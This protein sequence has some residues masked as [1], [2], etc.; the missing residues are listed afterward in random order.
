MI[1]VL[2]YLV[3]AWTEPTQSPP[4]GNVSAPL[5]VGNTGQSKSGGLIVNT[6]GAAVGFV[7]DKG[8]VGIGTTTPSGKLEVSGTGNVLLNTSGNVGIGTAYPSQK[9]EVSG[10]GLFT[11]D[12]CNGSGLCL[13]SVFQTNVIAGANANCPSGQIIIMKAWNGQ[14]YTADN[15]SITQWNKVSC[16]R[17]F[18]IDGTSLLVNNNHTGK[19]CTD[20]NG[21]VVNDGSG[22]N[23][24]RFK[25]GCGG[26][27]QQFNNWSTTIAGTCPTEKTHPFRK[28]SVCGASLP[29]HDWSNTP[30]EIYS[31]YG[32]VNTY[33]YPGTCGY[34]GYLCYIDSYT[35]AAWRCSN[36][37]AFG[38]AP[39]VEMG[40]F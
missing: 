10:N 36:E 37:G 26:G 28:Y 20:L 29:H 19:Q 9:L 32:W 21:T 13:S 3:L 25:G 8:N 18:T 27:W 7:V 15:P 11:G 4:E 35:T 17:Q 2:N 33:W 40:C 16:G 14:W 12:V 23:F 5:N 34:C 30:V 6:G 39:I 24:C 31:S 38:S 22:N 1:F